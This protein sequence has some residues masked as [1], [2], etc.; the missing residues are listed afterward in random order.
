MRD[1]IVFYRSFYEAVKDLPADQ[2]KA[3]V[4]A[5]MDY[6]LD[7]TVPE[8]C[9]IEKTVYLMAKPQ[10]D[11]N[12]KRYLNGTKGGRPTTKKEPNNNQNKTEAY[13]GSN[14]PVTKA[15]PN[16]NDNDNVNDI[17]KKDTKV[18]KEK[19]FQPPSVENVREYCQEGGY[20]VDAEYFV[21]FYTAKD[22][23]VG[24]NKMKD[25]KAAVR[26]WTRNNREEGQACRKA[27][28]ADRYNQGILKNE[29]DIEALERDLLGG[30]G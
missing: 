20:R 21:D 7:G 23:M 25:W 22:W 24:K 13:P 4:K 15:E 19:S 27:S 18:S 28:A 29:I 12:N 8:T 26:N 5:I 9:G 6:G 1:S 2:F 30:M 16:V 11:V 17:K 14:H 10:I 3:C